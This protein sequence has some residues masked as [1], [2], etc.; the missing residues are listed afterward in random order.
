MQKLALDFGDASSQVIADF[1]DTTV[2]SMPNLRD[3]AFGDSGFT[4]SESA[5][6]LDRDHANLLLAVVDRCT[7]LRKVSYNF[8]K[9]AAREDEVLHSKIQRQC[10]MNRI[11]YTNLLAGDVPLASWPLVL[12]NVRQQ[13]VLFSLICE[14][15][16]L[17]LMNVCNHRHGK[18][19]RADE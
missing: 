16:D 19:K 13:D 12:A 11:G 17:L 9:E 18:R 3:L 8:P 6:T 7:N 5:M 2:P 1:I 14:K 15:N 10:E 4:G